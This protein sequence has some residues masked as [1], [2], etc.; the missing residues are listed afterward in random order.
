MPLDIAPNPE[1]FWVKVR[2]DDN[3][4][5]IVHRL[6]REETDDPRPR[7]TSHFETCPNASKHSKKNK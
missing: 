4:D 3:G 1:G 7:Y 5:K 2:V 6:N